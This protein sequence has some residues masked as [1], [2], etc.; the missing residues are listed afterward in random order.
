MMTWIRKGLRSAFRQP[1]AVVCLFV[2][3]LLWGFYL[4]RYVQSFVSPL[5]HRYPG[6]ALPASA[7]QLFF[8]ES[9]FRLT[10][11]DLLEPY[12]WTLA[13]LLAV[14]MAVTPLLNA[15]VYYSLQ[16]PDLNAGY[17]FF[18]G[19]KELGGPYFLLYAIL[20]V[21][22]AAPLPWLIGKAGALY[23]KHY[24]TSK[25]V[26]SLLPYAGAYLAYLFLLH[27]LFMYMQFGRAAG[28]RLI[29]TLLCWLGNGHRIV[30]IALAVG[31]VALLLGA[32]A[33]GASYVWAGL[34]ALLVHQ[35][36]PLVRM[37]L[38]VWGIAAQHALWRDKA[39]T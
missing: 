37:V 7:S 5:L 21:F 32:A 10:K 36:Y 20:V 24:L 38:K 9:Q 13:G 8:A 39:N 3:E 12:L 19:M 1:F 18:R 23:E 22:S 28:V 16:R 4:Y 11:T 14:R 15:A 29:P 35:L 30:G 2:Y 31:L 27:L 34:T 25:M 6:S 26:V 33:A 17:R